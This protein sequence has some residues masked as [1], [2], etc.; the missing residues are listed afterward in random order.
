MK[1]DSAETRTWKLEKT[2]NQNSKIDM[3]GVMT[4]TKRMIAFDKNILVVKVKVEKSLSSLMYTEQDK[5]ALK[6]YIDMVF[7]IDYDANADVDELANTDTVGELMNNIY[8][9][10]IPEERRV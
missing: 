8:F 10:Y 3:M 7:F 1:K 5:K 6:W 4:R 2:T 9:N